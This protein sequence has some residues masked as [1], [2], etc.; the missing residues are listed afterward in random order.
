ML[1]RILNIG[2]FF[3]LSRLA[4]FRLF[5]PFNPMTS[6]LHTVDVH[7]TAWLARRCYIDIANDHPGASTLCQRYLLTSRN[8]IENNSDI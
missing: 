6:T 7:A 2:A 5:T 8:W 3:L 4:S 1:A